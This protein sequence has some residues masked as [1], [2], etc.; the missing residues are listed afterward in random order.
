MKKDAVECNRC[1]KNLSTACPML[2][3]IHLQENADIV[4]QLC[5]DQCSSPNVSLLEH[6]AP[7]FCS[8]ILRIYWI[9]TDSWIF[10]DFSTCG[11]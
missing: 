4:I 2:V 8:L 9:G 1:S 7:D 3:L 5:A 10:V 11:P 6:T